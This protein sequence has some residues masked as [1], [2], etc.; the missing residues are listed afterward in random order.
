M[1]KSS[2]EL[3]QTKSCVNKVRKRDDLLSSSKSNFPGKDFCLNTLGKLQRSGQIDVY[4]HKKL[5]H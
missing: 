3:H 5:G 2:Y 4:L 1:S